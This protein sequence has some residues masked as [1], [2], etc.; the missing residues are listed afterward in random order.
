MPRLWKHRTIEAF[1]LHAR[2]QPHFQVF[3]SWFSLLIFKN[4]WQDSKEQFKIKGEPGR[5]VCQVHLD[6]KFTKSA[7]TRVWD[8]K[9]RRQRW[10]KET[11]FVAYFPSIHLTNAEDYQ[12]TFSGNIDDCF[13][14]GMRLARKNMNIFSNFYSSDII[15]ASPLGLRMI[16]GA[17]GYSITCC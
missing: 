7:A 16:I 12:K 13:R 14:V 6:I 2:H 8:R 5:W 4:A 17:P 9:R 15:I 10:Y 11:R 3:S 1:V